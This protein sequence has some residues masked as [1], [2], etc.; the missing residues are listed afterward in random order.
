MG[1]SYFDLIGARYGYFELTRFDF[2]HD[3]ITN[4]SFYYP[5]R[6]YQTHECSEEEYPPYKTDRT[7]VGS[8]LYCFDDKELMKVI[9]SNNYD[10]NQTFFKIFA[11]KNCPEGFS[12]ES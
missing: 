8:K 6:S 1:P 9:F 2:F 11:S 4:G 10:I 12:T 5:T 3:N 7:L